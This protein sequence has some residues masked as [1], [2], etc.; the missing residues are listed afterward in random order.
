MGKYG[1]M[2][3]KG[4]GVVVLEIFRDMGY[5]ETRLGLVVLLHCF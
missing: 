2:G 5:R 1:V 3:F 4:R